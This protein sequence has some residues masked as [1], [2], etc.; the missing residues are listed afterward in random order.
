MR[1]GNDK[2]AEVLTHLSAYHKYRMGDLAMRT[3]VVDN[4]DT[5]VMPV[6]SIYICTVIIDREREDYRIQSATVSGV[7]PHEEIRERHPDIFHNSFIVIKDF[8]K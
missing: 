4:E 3:Q 1:D 8:Q 6:E 2:C 7:Q 5:K